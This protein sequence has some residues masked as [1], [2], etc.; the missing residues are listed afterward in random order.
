[1]QVFGLPGHII[2][3]A[4]GASRLLAAQTPDIEAARRRDALARWRKRHG[5]R[6]DAASRRPR[7]WASRAPPSTA[8][9]SAPRR[10]A[11]GRAGACAKRPATGGSPQPSS[12]CAWTHPM[13]GKEKLGPILRKPGLRRIQRH[14]RAHHRRAHPARHGFSP[15]PP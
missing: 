8:G 6:A 7:R 11:G 15:F 14:R 2:R 4:R 1:M 9:E 13:W 5:A 12:A 3:N 10:R